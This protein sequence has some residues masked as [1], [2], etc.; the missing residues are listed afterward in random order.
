MFQRAFKEY[1]EN[2]AIITD[3]NECITY[4]ELQ[5]ITEQIQ[6]PVKK[7]SLIFCLCEN[8]VAS[9][10]GYISFID[11][12]NVPLLID[13]EINQNLLANL[14]DVYQPN[15]LWLPKRKLAD[16]S[17][18]KQIITSY[19]YT[20][21][22]LNEQE[23][24]LSSDL[25]LLLTTSGSTG[26]PKLVRLTKENMYSNAIAIVEYL[27]ITASERPVTSLPMHYSYGLSVINSH[28]ISGATLLL[29]N[30]SIV[31]KEFWAFV[32]EQ[33]ASSIAGV[34]NTY[35]MLK[36]LRFFTMKLPDLKTLTQAG[37]KLSANIIAEYAAKCKEIGKQFIVMYGQTEAT[38]RMSYLPFEF[39]EIKSSSI[40]IAI[41]GG[42]FQI[43]DDE[44]AEITAT[45]MDGELVY[46]GK[47]V[48]MGYAESQIDLQKG[49]ENN[50]RLL[51]GDIAKKDKDGYYYI[52]G[53]KKRFI[54]IYG[55]RIN[56]D[57]VEQLLRMNQ[58]DCVCIGEDDKLSV[59][60]T[61]PDTETIIR[62]FLSEKTGLHSK[63]FEIK[64]ITE[65][66]KNSSGKV[67]YANLNNEL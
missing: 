51:T 34:P 57:E 10:A 55:N 18:Q 59:F 48:S 23:I 36:M 15:Y 27:N 28:L 45:E 16:F 20:L 47:N 62:S 14:I 4:N 2:I 9:I 43:I 63:A 17:K 33:K 19:D 61:Q 66:P 49:D 1:T 3:T 12:N 56:L 53:R 67:L 13:A 64:Y 39:A 7:R 6:A 30:L 11:H 65:I 24:S 38:A 5:V 25:S 8:S 31:Q 58:F 37:G 60:T 46:I 26:S 40:G 52:T 54:K 50:G 41:P 22:Q 21:V 42:A 32:R 35:E 29:T 44:G